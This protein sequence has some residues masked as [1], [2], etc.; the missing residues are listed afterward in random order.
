MLDEVEGR[1]AGT[2]Q[3]ALG[4]SSFFG[5]QYQL[6]GVHQGYCLSFVFA[7]STSNGEAVCVFTGLERNGKLQTVWHMV[8]D[9]ATNGRDKR[10]GPHAVMTNADTFTRD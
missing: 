10:A 4:D 6:V 7:G 3:T 8:S 2:F 1:L 9:R 5:P